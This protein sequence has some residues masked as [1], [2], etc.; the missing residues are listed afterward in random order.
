MLQVT[1][2]AQ[3][4]LGEYLKQNSVQSAV[5]VYMADGCCSG[6]SL[7]LGLDEQRES[8][9]AMEAGGV[10]YLIDQALAEQVGGVT[11]DYVDEGT[12]AGFTIFSEKPLPAG[13]GQCGSCSC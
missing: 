4:K 9:H 6:A 5:R 8:D 2:L 10:T 7:S 3:E 12:R 11:I 13:D 1:D